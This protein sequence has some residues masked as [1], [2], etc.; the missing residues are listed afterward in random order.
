MFAVAAV[1]L[2]DGR[3]LLATGSDE[4]TVQLWDPATGTPVGDPLTGHTKSV[5]A[6]AAVLL[7]DGRTLLA[8]GSGRDATV[9]LWDPATGTPCRRPADRPHQVRVGGGGR[10]AARRRTLLATGSVDQT[11]RLWDPTDGAGLK[12]LPVGRD[13]QSYQ[14]AWR[15]RLAVALDGGLLVLDLAN[16]IAATEPTGALKAS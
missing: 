14:P 1:P 15:R 9:R 11:V 8:T 5:L 10:A 12:R 7:P 16:D 13:R 3:T 4:R 2:P 6:V